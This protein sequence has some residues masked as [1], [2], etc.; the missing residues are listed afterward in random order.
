[1]RE[2]QPAINRDPILSDS[3]SELKSLCEKEN[4]QYYGPDNL[5]CCGVPM[6]TGAGPFG[7]DYACCGCCGKILAN[8]SSPRINGGIIPSDNFLRL[9]GQQTWVRTGPHGTGTGKSA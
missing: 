9:H 4:V 2:N 3:L 1:M 6:Y 5:Y 7:P 8:I